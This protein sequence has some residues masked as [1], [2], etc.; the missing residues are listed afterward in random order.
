MQL[1][2]V[3]DRENELQGLVCSEIVLSDE[4]LTQFAGH[5]CKISALA[6]KLIFRDI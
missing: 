1:L 5:L 4:A 3:S 6:T 2:D